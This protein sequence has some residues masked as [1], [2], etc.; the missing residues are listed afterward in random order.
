MVSGVSGVA[1]VS[2]VAGVSGIASVSGVSG[3]VGWDEGVG[4]VIV[5]VAGGGAIAGDVTGVVGCG[6]EAI[7]AVATV[8]DG[9]ATTGDGLAATVEAV[10]SVDIVGRGIVRRTISLVVE[11]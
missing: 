11:K 7:V 6:G 3:G 10:P 5:A 2:G 4:E 9:A 1:S 8:G